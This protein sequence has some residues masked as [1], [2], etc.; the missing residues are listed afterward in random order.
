[1]EEYAEYLDENGMITIKWWAADYAADD[2]HDDDAGHDHDHDH[3]HG[4]VAAATL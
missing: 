2:G 4:H 3:D 1:V